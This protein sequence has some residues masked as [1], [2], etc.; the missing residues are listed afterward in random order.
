M[1]SD[2]A[3]SAVDLELCA[4]VSFADG[5]SVNDVMNTD[6]LFVL[7]VNI[8]KDGQILHHFLST[9]EYLLQYCESS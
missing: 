4:P 2:S 1:W 6:I 3:T 7:S 5:L 9:T 8:R